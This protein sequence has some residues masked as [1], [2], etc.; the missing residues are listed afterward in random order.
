MKARTRARTR[1]TPR[2]VK[3]ATRHKRARRDGLLAMGGYHVQIE[4]QLGGCAVCGW[5]PGPGQRRLAVDHD[6]KTGQVRGLLC[7]AHNRTL[8]AC[9]DDADALFGLALYLKHGWYAAVVYRE[10]RA[11][12]QAEREPER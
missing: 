10:A 12:Q 7:I 4:R 8:G 2:K 3:A 1:T 9:R 11:H 5:K 6:H